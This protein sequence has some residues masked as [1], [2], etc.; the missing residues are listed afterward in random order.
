VALDVKRGEMEQTGIVTEET[1]PVIAALAQQLTDSAA[2][3]IVIEVLRTRIATDGAPVPLS[4]PK[5]C[6]SL[7]G[8]PVLPIEISVAV[9]KALARLAPT[10][11]ARRS[12]RVP[13]VVLMSYGLL[14]RRTPPKSV[15]DPGMVAHRHSHGATALAVVRITLGA[16]AIE[17]IKGQAVAESLISAEVRC[18]LRLPTGRATLACHGVSPDY[19]E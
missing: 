1:E 3:M 12:T 5:L 19:R 8:E 13:A 14:T 7:T 17:T 11:E 16:I 15:G 9:R 4:G 6:E 18:R 10:T 2:L